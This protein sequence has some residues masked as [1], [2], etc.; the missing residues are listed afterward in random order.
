MEQGEVRLRLRKREFVIRR[1]L[2]VMWYVMT[3][4]FSLVK[5][6]IHYIVHVSVQSN[7]LIYLTIPIFNGI[8]QNMCILLFIS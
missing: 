1:K 6:R 5:K 8:Y 2:K 7:Q 3:N 4:M